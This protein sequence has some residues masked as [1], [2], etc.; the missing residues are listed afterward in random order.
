MHA[1]NVHNKFKECT[2][3]IMDGGYVEN[4]GAICDHLIGDKQVSKF[5]RRVKR[6]RY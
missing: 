2:V 1:L 3:I 5:A 6:L 4:A